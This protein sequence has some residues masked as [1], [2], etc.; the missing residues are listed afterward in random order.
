MAWWLSV[1]ALGYKI[2][3]PDQLLPLFVMEIAEKVPGLPGIF[4]S[5]VFSAALSTMS[6]GLNSMTGV[7][8]EDMIKPL[9]KNVI[10]EEKASYIMKITVIIIGVLC[11]AMV[12]IVEQLGTLIQAGKSL[13]GI[14]AGSLLGVFTLGMFFPWANEKGALVG[15]IISLITVGWI[16]VSSQKEIARGNIKFPRKP[17]SVAG[18]PYLL[19]NITT[20]QTFLLQKNLSSEPFLL[21]EI[22]YLWYTLAGLLITLMVGITV[23]FLYGFND[24]ADVDRKL[25]TPLIHRF[26]PTKETDELTVSLKERKRNAAFVTPAN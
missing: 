5:G 11:V 14:T 20:V 19:P 18:C 1:D 12:F 9:S 22:S 25:L 13:S 8:Y 24:P 15:G 2:K 21:F 17:V 6:T 26:L 16:S 7:I 10:S 3:K 4:L 23:S